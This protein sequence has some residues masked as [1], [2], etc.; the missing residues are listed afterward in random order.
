MKMLSNTFCASV[1]KP[2]GTIPDQIGR[3]RQKQNAGHSYSLKLVCDCTRKYDLINRPIAVGL[4]LRNRLR[5]FEQ[6]QITIED[7]TYSDS[8]F[9]NNVGFGY[10]SHL[11]SEENWKPEGEESIPLEPLEANQ[12]MQENFDYIMDEMLPSPQGTKVLC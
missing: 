10:I 8:L 9:W 3:R 7:H 4:S 1:R 5:Q 6:H 11:S 2:G 12:I